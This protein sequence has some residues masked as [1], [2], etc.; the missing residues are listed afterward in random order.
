MFQRKQYVAMRDGVKLYTVVW[1]PKEK[2]A[3]P[4]LLKRSPYMQPNNYDDRPES[5]QFVTVIQS[6]RG[7]GLSEG[8][9]IPFWNERNDGLDTLDWIRRQDFYNGRIYIEGE[10]YLSAAHLSYLSDGPKDIIG[11]ALA[12][13]DNDWYNMCYE[14][15]QYKLGLVHVWA[16][17]LAA[18]RHPEINGDMLQ[19]VLTRPACDFKS[20]VI[21]ANLSSTFNFLCNLMQHPQKHDPFWSDDPVRRSALSAAHGIKWPLCLVSG[22]YDIALTGIWNLWREIQPQVRA[23]SIFVITPYAHPWKGEGQIAMN[24]DRKDALF[25]LMASW[26]EICRSGADPCCTGFKTGKTNCYVLFGDRW[27]CEDILTEGSKQL[28][29]Y[30]NGNALSRCPGD[31]T[32]SYVYDPNN[33]TCFEGICGNVFGRMELQPDTGTRS[34][35]ISFI[36]EPFDKKVTVKGAQRITLKVSSDCPDTAFYARVSLVRSD[37]TTY[38]LRDRITS[39]SHELDAYTPSSSV[40]I[41]MILDPIAFEIK[42]SE[43]LRLDIASACFPVYY[44]HS[45]TDQLWSSSDSCEKATNILHLAD[46]YIDLFYEN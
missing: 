26:R 36:S 27:I 18:R 46:C 11:G 20:R 9:F 31:G 19:A 13:M 40:I 32:I 45:N 43:K 15:G 30:L 2:S 41:R 44:P 24:N 33:P 4:V 34:D 6:T 39:L 29:L 14:N 3:C 1:L 23:K 37:N 10:S 5:E 8:D 21:N 35:I 22:H 16:T 25:S 42:P 7:T 17:A 38:P 28:R 12:V